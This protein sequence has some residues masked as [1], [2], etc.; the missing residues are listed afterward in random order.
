MQTKHY[1]F[2]ILLL[3]AFSPLFSQKMLSGQPCGTTGKTPWLEWYQQHRNELAQERGTDTAWLYVPMTLH[4]VGTDNGSGYFK[5][6]Q[7]IRAVCEMND[8]YAD[9][10]IRFYLYPGDPVRYHD[11]TSWY[12]H[13]YYPGGDEMINDNRLPDR[14]NAFVVADPA[15]NCGYSWQDAIVLGSGCSGIGNSTWAHEAGHHL[16]LPHPFVGWEGTSWNYNNP[17]PEKVGGQLVEKT[18]S[19]NCFDASDGFCDTRP[20]YL[21]YRWTCDDNKLSITAQR[22]PDSVQFRSDATLIMGYALDACASRF[23]PEQIEAMR[24][25]LYFNHFS[26]LQITDP[27]PEI[28]DNALVGLI[29]PVDSQKVQYNDITLTWNPVPGATMYVV[30]VGLPPSL[31]PKFYN[32]TVYNTTSVTITKGIP[33]NRLMKWR[34][35]AYSEWDICQPNDNAQ[36]GYFSTKNL[37]ATNDLEQVAQAELSPNPVAGGFPALLTVS[38]D[39]SMDAVLH[40]TDAAGRLC[41]SRQVR[42]SPGDNALEIPTDGLNAG[43]YVVTLRNE[44]GA[45][46]KRLAVA[47]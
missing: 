44:K 3:N 1:F 12:N 7:A 46:V 18:D 8:Q 28:D 22:D 24:S 13:E 47:E 17:A 36:G 2:V 35:R 43:F 45:L 10:H 29:S 14:L 34:V 21:N 9:A 32:Q 40:I 26:Y 27:L 39:E 33:N 20:D 38:T 42:L 37:S 41:Q 25:D 15:G 23:T 31:S 6:E 11:N 16:S 19:S 30:E 4:L 5:L